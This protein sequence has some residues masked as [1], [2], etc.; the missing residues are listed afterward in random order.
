MRVTQCKN[1]CQTCWFEGTGQLVDQVSLAGQVN[2]ISLLRYAK[3]SIRASRF[4]FTLKVGQTPC[5]SWINVVWF[6]WRLWGNRQEVI[7]DLLVLF[8]ILELTESILKKC[9]VFHFYG[10]SSAERIQFCVPVFD[11]RGFVISGAQKIEA[12]VLFPCLKVPAPSL[13]PSIISVRQL[14]MSNR[15]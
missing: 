10:S 5:G 9:F 3:S 15:I 2:A 14:S 13:H 8:L 4:N 1:I 11:L 6:L 7:S 12:I